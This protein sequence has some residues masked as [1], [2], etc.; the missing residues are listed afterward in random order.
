MKAVLIL[1]IL[2]SIKSFALEYYMYDFNDTHHVNTTMRQGI[3]IDD[4]SI[5]GRLHIRSMTYKS[6]TYSI[7]WL[8]NNTSLSKSDIDINSIYAPF[9]VLHNR[10]GFLIDEIK[11]LSKDKRVNDK[12]MGIVDGLQFIAKKEGVFSF[13]NSLGDIKVNQKIIKDKYNITY[14]SQYTKGKKREDIKY[15]E[16]N[17]TIMPDKNLFWSWV[18]IYEKIKIKV[19][20][21]KAT[22]ID[23]RSSYLNK[24]KEILDKEHWFFKLPFDISK[25]NFKPYPH[26]KKISYK[27]ASD[28]F[29]IKEAE[30]KAIADDTNKVAQWVLDNMDFL[31]HLSQLL[32]EHTLDDEV[33]RV[34]FS[35]LGYIDNT[36]GSNIL[37]DVFLNEDIDKKE[38]FRSLMALKNTSAP[39]DEEKLDMLIDYGLNSS[40]ETL[41][42]SSGMLLGTI[43]KNRIVRVPSQYEKI[44]NAISNA[45]RNSNNKVVAIDAGANMKDSVSQEVLESI[46]DVLLYDNSYL[47]RKK[48]A[49]ALQD[50]QKSNLDVSQFQKLLN[51]E[52]DS[53]TKAE[54][55]KSSITAQN[56][57][58][59]IEYHNFLENL[60]ENKKTVKSNRLS[61]LEVLDKLG[62]GKTQA[63]KEKIRKMMVGE[64]DRDIFIKL[65]E[66]YRR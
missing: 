7:F 59:N 38:R 9:M 25:W 42:K 57:K 30:L 46:E 34:L 29:D 47:Y 44:S 3:S 49:E 5:I 21:P 14:L 35:N 2:L 48:S 39:I 19:A 40:D 20:I 61:A 58:N 11:T 24:T 33:S 23:Y 37:S 22:I 65:K 27:S 43:A 26:Q 41:Q 50:I 17:I 66:L 64:K 52:Q 53:D 16:S 60:S 13:P 4:I 6:T 56:I 28:M 32:Q 54:I 55:I 1:I 36:Q 51:Q 62:F 31:S 10:D 18:K 12:I 45:I 63:D 15:L 8:E